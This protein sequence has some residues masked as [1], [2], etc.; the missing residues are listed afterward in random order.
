MERDALLAL[1][2]F[3]L[4]SVAL[5]AGGAT[6]SQALS[7][8]TSAVMQLGDKVGPENRLRLAFYLAVRSQLHVELSP[9]LEDR[10]QVKEICDDI[11]SRFTDGS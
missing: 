2:A 11:G 6:Q 1:K 7:M 8:L 9:T 5:R 4:G 3:H 10:A